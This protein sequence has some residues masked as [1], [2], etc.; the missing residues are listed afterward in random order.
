[1]IGLAKGLDIISATRR[2]HALEHATVTVLLERFGFT[3]SLAGR[4]NQ[5]GFNIFGNV[6]TQELRSAVDEGLARLLF[7]KYRLKASRRSVNLYRRAAA[8][9]A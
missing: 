1:M 4:S 3:R 9:S 2:N 5:R 6:S 7:S 8:K